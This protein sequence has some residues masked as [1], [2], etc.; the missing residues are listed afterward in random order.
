MLYRLD[1]CPWIFFKDRQRLR[2]G[3]ADLDEKDHPPRYKECWDHSTVWGY[4]RYQK[5]I[6]SQFTTV[7]ESVAMALEYFSR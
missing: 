5:A 1:E 2:N 3:F 4:D 6:Q 7:M